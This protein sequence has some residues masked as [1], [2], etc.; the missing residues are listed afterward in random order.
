RILSRD[1]WKNRFIVYQNAIDSFYQA[2]KPEILKEKKRP[3]DVY[4]SLRGVIDNILAGDDLDVIKGNIRD[5]LDQ[6]VTVQE[7]HEPED[8]NS[9]GYNIEKEPPNKDT[10]NQYGVIKESKEYDLR[11]SG[12][13]EAKSQFKKREQKNIDI[14]QLRVFLERKLEQM[15]TRNSMRG[16][17]ADRY[18]AIVDRYNSGGSSTE[19]Y[20]EDLV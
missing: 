2:C 17:F 6:S 8:G 9:S 14:T 13:Q 19:N 20:Y 5:L 11:K 3:A 10:N 18:R 7:E 15:L 16:D 12:A 1:D 4:K